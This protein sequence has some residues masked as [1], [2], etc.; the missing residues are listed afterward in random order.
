VFEGL[1]QSLKIKDV[2]RLNAVVVIF[3]KAMYAKAMEIKWKHKEQFRDII[4]RMGACHTI[5]T[6]LG[7]IGKRFQ[8]AGLRNLCVESQVIAEG[9]VSGV[10]CWKYNRNTTVLCGCTSLCTRP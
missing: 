4:V 8:D 10:L 7:I 9:S 1:S 6:L 3:D 5:C 2:L